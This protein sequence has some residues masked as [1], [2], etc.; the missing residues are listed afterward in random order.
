MIMKYLTKMQEKR[1]FYNI[2]DDQNPLTNKI[3][4]RKT[5]SSKK[6]PTGKTESKSAYLFIS[7]AKVKQFQKQPKKMQESDKKLKEEDKEYLIKQNVD[8]Y[9]DAISN[10]TIEKDVGKHS[11]KYAEDNLDKSDEFILD[12]CEEKTET[13]N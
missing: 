13:K 4:L 3:L 8:H 7:K 6:M 5:K 12:D 1:K 11:N 2:E 10:K 9:S